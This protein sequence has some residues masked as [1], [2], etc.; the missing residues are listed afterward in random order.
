MVSGLGGVGD[1]ASGPAALFSGWGNSA[2]ILMVR[3][4]IPVCRQ[5]LYRLAFPLILAIWAG[6]TPVLSGNIRPAAAA[7]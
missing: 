6:T 3:G 1:G 2:R 5:R 7:A 4:L